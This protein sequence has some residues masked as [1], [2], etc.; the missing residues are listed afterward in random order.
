MNQPTER[1]KKPRIIMVSGKGGVGKTTVAAS[2]AV[3]LANRGQKTIVMSFDLAHSLSDSFNISEELFSTAKGRPVRINDN[4]DFQEIDV[5][6]ELQRNWGEVYRYIAYLLVGGGLDGIVAEEAAVMPGMEDIIALLHINQYARE[7]IYDTIV[8]DCPP[9]SESLRFVSI[10][11]SIDWYVRKRLKLDRRV[12][13]VLRP[14]AK[15]FGGESMMLPEDGYF[16]AL[17]KLFERLDGV[18]AMLH[19]PTITSLRL[20]TVAD[21]MVVRE[22]QRAFM[23]FNLY[24]I[25]VDGVVVNRMLPKDDAY[26]ARWVESQAQMLETVHS[27][28]DPVPISTVPFQQSEVVGLERLEEFADHLFGDSDPAAVNTSGAPFTFT[29]VSEDEHLLS[30]RLRFAPKDEIEISRSN[31][32]LFVRIGTFKRVILLPRALVSMATAGAK[33]NGDWLEIRFRKDHV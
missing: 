13:S 31:E 27:F 32:D 23:Y 3:A 9:T 8:V 24:G 14:L 33:M 28:F 11:G 12:A 21:R 26:F 25:T 30:I 15:R 22:T 6:E 4:L 10:I 16:A 18:E 19:D 7:G 29:K 20:V 5:Q 17:Q 1:S 2:T